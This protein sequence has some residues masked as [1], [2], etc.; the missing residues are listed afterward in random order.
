M[1]TYEVTLKTHLTRPGNE[2]I[3]PSQQN[4]WDVAREVLEVSETRADLVEVT[5]TPLEPSRQVTRPAPQQA[6]TNRAS[7]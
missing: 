6:G 1:I 5:A 4:V 7:V 3:D 2:R